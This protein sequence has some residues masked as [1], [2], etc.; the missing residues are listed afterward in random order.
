MSKEKP[1]GTIMAIMVDRRVDVAPTVQTVLTKHGCAIRMRIGLHETDAEY[2]ANWGLI[3]L[4]VCGNCGDVEALT[5]DLKAIEGV[6]VKSMCLE[7]E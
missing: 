3:L 7:F 5:N 1:C 6:K 2:C 4:Q